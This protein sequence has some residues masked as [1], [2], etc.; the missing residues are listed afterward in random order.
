MLSSIPKKQGLYESYNN[1]KNDI[2]SAAY[3]R[4]IFRILLKRV[5]TPQRRTE[6][7]RCPTVFPGASMQQLISCVN[8]TIAK[9]R[10]LMFFSNA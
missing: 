2:K 7:G 6:L 1:F 3:S 8:S 5:E 9:D 10:G 4:C